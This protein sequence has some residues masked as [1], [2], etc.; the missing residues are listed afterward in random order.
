HDMVLCTQKDWVKIR[1]QELGG[2]ALRAIIIDLH[3]IDDPSSL[4][5][6]LENCAGEA[7]QSSVSQSSASQFSASQSSASQSKASPPAGPRTH[8]ST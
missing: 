7:P 4:F 3:W 8:S 5:G 6:D 1:R 2:K